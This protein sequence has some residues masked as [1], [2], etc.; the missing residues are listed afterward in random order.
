ME[1]C[2]LQSRTRSHFSTEVDQKG[3]FLDLSLVVKESD[4]PWIVKIQKRQV[5]GSRWCLR[6]MECRV[7]SDRSFV[8]KRQTDDDGWLC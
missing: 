4:R 1:I 2:A 7:P 3:V 6:C 5:E 8:S